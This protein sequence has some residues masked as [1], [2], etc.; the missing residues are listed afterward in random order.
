MFPSFRKMLWL[1][2]CSV[3][4]LLGCRQTPPPDE[5]PS[6]V[7]ETTVFQ[8]Y[9]LVLQGY[10]DGAARRLFQAEME[11]LGLDVEL[12][13]SGANQAE[14]QVSPGNGASEEWIQSLSETFAEQYAVTQAGPR[15]LFVRR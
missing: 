11:K 2:L 8:T 3:F 4:L 6:A 13:Q 1:S 7:H 15:L 10:E 12:L 5:P 14:Y 9:T